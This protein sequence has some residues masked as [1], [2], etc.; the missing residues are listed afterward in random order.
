MPGVTLL[1]ADRVAVAGRLPTPVSVALGS[2]D[3][4]HQLRARVLAEADIV[5]RRA[6]GPLTSTE[7]AWPVRD[8]SMASIG[9]SG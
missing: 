4:T 3:R 1:R 5:P 9:A 6:L 2:G 7:E 8:L